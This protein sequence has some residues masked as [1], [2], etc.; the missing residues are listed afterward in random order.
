[1]NTD[2]IFHSVLLFVLGFAAGVVAHC[3]LVRWVHRK[4]LRDWEK[5]HETTKGANDGR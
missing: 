2:I 3:L 4:L 5:K 1:M